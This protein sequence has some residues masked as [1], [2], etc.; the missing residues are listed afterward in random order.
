M[1]QA[2]LLA[3]LESVTNRLEKLAS[4]MGKGGSG[5]EGG[6]GDEIPPYVAAY[7]AIVDNQVKNAVKAINDLG[8]PD[9]GTWL[10]QGFDNINVL[11]KAT[12]SCKKTSKS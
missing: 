5:G 4:S 12:A 7:Q 9:V 11:I 6:G 10:Q 8:I 1:A 3:R 2:D